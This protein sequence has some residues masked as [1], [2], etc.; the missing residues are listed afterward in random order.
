MSLPT[1]EGSP[2]QPSPQFDRRCDDPPENRAGSGPDRPTVQG[3]STY[4][5]YPGFNADRA[6]PSI[7]DERDMVGGKR[8]GTNDLWSNDLTVED[9]A[10]Y[11]LRIYIHNSAADSDNT[12][13]TGTR[14]RLP[15][16]TCEGK[17]IAI[18]GFV[19]SVDAF[20]IEVWAG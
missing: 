4:L 20:P 3:L 17:H 14:V 16:P 1:I 5:F 8:A 6:S 12:V 18:N 9:G 7:G 19:H 11:T 10:T 15:L 13:A 2:G